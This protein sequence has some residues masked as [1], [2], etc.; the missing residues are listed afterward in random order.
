M[1]S[2][3]IEIIYFGAFGLFLLGSALSFRENGSYRAVAIM[4][5][6]VLA[7][8]AVRLLPLADSGYAPVSAAGGNSYISFAVAAGM[9]TVWPAYLL[10]LLFWR[11]KNKSF[12][13]W[14]IAG[15]EI[16]WFA[17]II[18]LLYGLYGVLLRL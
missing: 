6:G 2:F 12:F 1:P 3:A 5:C 14:M 10:A 4:S 7:D 13:H 9:G 18:L 15:I 8:M 16:V 11:Q 17:D